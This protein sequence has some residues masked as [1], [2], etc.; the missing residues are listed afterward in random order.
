MAEGRA[1]RWPRTLV[2]ISLFAMVVVAFFTNLPYVGRL[3]LPIQ[4]GILFA[5]FVLGL[6]HWQPWLLVNQFIGW[7]G[8]VSFSAYLV[9]LAVISSLP[10]PHENYVESFLALT[11]I[12]IAISSFTYLAIE[13]PCNRLGA[14]L[15]RL[16]AKARSRPSV[17]TEHASVSVIKE[18]KAAGE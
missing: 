12:T 18:I 7:I 4:Y 17:I 10:I 3:G 6:A 14:R 2:L 9:H 16:L 5:V 1:T 13:M 8:K 15:A 11:T